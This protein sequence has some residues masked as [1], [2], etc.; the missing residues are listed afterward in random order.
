MTGRTITCS[1][2]LGMAPVGQWIPNWIR[3]SCGSCSSNPDF[4]M[5]VSEV[6]ETW[7]GATWSTVYPGTPSGGDVSCVKPAFCEWVGHADGSTDVYSWNG[8]SWSNI[9][10]PSADAVTLAA[11]LPS[12]TVDQPYSGVMSASGG[13]PPYSWELVKGEG[14]LPAGRKLHKA[15]G[16]ISGKCKSSGTSTFTV[17]VTDKETKKVGKAPRIQNTATATLSIT[18]APAS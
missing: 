18:I 7:D 5:L 14:T 1:S 11:S 9:P 2:K 8:T 10:S 15:T 16:A 3:N 4:C 12:G 6:D 13:N 17:E